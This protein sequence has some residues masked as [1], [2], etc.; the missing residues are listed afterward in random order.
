MTTISPPKQK[1][2]AKATGKSSLWKTKLFHWEFWPAQIA[3][4]PVV[5]MWLYFAIKARHLFFFSAANPAIETGGVLGESKIDILNQIPA[6]YKPLTLFHQAGTSYPEWM[7]SIEKAGLSFPLITKPNVGERGLGVEKI[8][9]HEAFMDYLKYA[10]YDLIVQEYVDYPEEYSVLHYRFPQK[11]KG[12][13]TSLCRK[14]YLTVKGDGEHTIRQ[15]IERYPRAMFQLEALESRW[16]KQ[17]D[18]VPHIGEKVLLNPIGNH[19]RGTTFLD[20]NAKITEALTH[21]FDEIN[22]Q[23]T[24]IHLCRYDLKCQSL[25]DLENGQNFKILE[26]NGVAGEPAHVYDPEYSVRQAYKDLFYHWKMVYQVARNLHQE[27]GVPYMKLGE[28]WSSLKK[29][30]KYVKTF[31]KK[32]N[33]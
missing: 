11:D 22:K 9:N 4:I 30:L 29:H 21:T 28:A 32:R 12:E 17:L 6:A 15:L 13:I 26:I 7:D 33:N 31:P 24:G 10:N 25:H 16:G 14:I 18:R 3:N 8:K 27:E 1:T 23:L 19:S 20:A 2:K 5:G